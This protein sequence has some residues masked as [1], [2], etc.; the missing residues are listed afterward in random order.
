LFLAV[1]ILSTCKIVTFPANIS[2]KYE[3]FLCYMFSILWLIEIIIRGTSHARSAFTACQS[4]LCC[5]AREAESPDFP[6][7]R[8]VGSAEAILIF[9]GCA[10]NFRVRK[11]ELSLSILGRCVGGGEEKFHSLL[12]SELYGCDW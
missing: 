12:T 2:D 4:L 9:H 6:F 8:T 3:V 11:E 10:D 7:F 5:L 1:L